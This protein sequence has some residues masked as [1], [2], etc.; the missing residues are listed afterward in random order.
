MLGLALEGGGAKGAFHMGAFKAFL[1]EGYEFHGVAGTS[2]GAI[3]GAIIAQ[4]DFEAGYKL[5]ETMDNTLLF[6]IEQ[7]QLQKIVDRKI[8]KETI[9]YLTAKI[10]EVIDNKGLDTSKIRAIIEGIIDED[11]LRKSKVDL[12][13]VTVSIPDLKPLELYKEDIPE[14]KM[15]AYLMASAN[16][17]VFKIEPLEGKFYIDGAFYDNCPVDLLARKGYEEVIAIRTFGPGKIRKVDYENIKVTSI[18]PSESLGRV[19]NFDSSIIHTNLSLG[20][21]DAMRAI[22]HL[23][24]RKYYIYPVDSETVFSSLAALPEEKIVKIGEIMSLPQMEPK[25]LLFEQVMPA[26]SQLLDLPPSAGYQDILVGVLE[27]VAEDL[28]IEKHKLRKLNDFLEEIKNEEKSNSPAAHTKRMSILTS[29]FSG[30]TVLKK[31]ASELLNALQ[32]EHFA[33]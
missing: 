18:I 11:K 21:C 5:W 22:K 1:E 6:D 20:Y 32:P 16:F 9:A 4:G 23:A 2:I 29:V 3:N 28:D 15:V 7:M 17:P 24:G 12:G 13:I 25:R 14:G 10:K 8:D 33:V 30:E 27:S 26:L 19:L 31:A